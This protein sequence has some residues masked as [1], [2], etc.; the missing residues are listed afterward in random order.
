MHW[1][2]RP[3]G[4]TAGF[5]LVE[6]LVVIAIIGVL[7][8]LLLPAVQAAREAARLTQCKNHLRQIG[9]AALNYESTHGVY[10]TGGWNAAWIGDPNVGFGARQ[11]GGWVYQIAPYL[12]TGPQTLPGVGVTGMIPLRDALAL[13]AAVPMPTMN[14][15]SRRV[16]TAY[17]AFDQEGLNFSPPSVAAKTDYAA[18]AGNRMAVGG[19]NKGPWIHTPFEGSQCSGLFPNC[20]W[21]SNDKW[22]REYWNG[23]VGDHSGARV[24]QLTDGASK[25][26]LA[27][28]K[29]VHTIYYDVASIDSDHDNQTN[30]VPHD[31]PGDNGSMYVGFDYDNVRAASSSLPPRRDTEY[32][33]RNPQ[34]DKKGKH[35][36]QNF[37][38][39]HSA[40]LVT[41]RCDAS[42][43]LMSFD[44]EPTVW[45]NYAAR[46]DGNELAL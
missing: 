41:V 26:M 46:N 38:G 13:L 7:V 5:T 29:W 20:R 12:E 37:G 11:P 17:P 33:R 43:H 4:R 18:N 19:R 14:C 34:S 3:T 22:L 35:Y 44:V 21:V 16:A 9:I 32:D 40:G 2:V 23:V 31:N 28:E 45:A 6:L 10:P 15:P 36:L 24:A 27:A 8:A 25:T 30:G 39:A 1:H 42:V